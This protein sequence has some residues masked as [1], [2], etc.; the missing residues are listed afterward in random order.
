M[1]LCNFCLEEFKGENKLQ[2][3]EGNIIG[4]LVTYQ[5]YYQNFEC[6]VLYWNNWQV[7]KVASKYQGSWQLNET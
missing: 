3:D 4:D 7:N 6:M 5:K 1:R 2:F